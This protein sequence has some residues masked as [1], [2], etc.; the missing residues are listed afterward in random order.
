MFR[1]FSVFDL[2]GI[3]PH[4][5]VCILSEYLQ[6]KSVETLCPVNMGISRFFYPVFCDMVYHILLKGK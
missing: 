6:N 5:H 2:R 3:L 4:Y 1:S